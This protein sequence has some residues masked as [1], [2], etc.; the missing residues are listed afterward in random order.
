M[1]TSSSYG[2]PKDTNQLIPPW[3]RPEIDPQSP[4]EPEK[5]S[6]PPQET[7]KQNDKTK[8]W[9]K[10]KNTMSR[11]ASNGGGV[12]RLRKAGSAYTAAKGGA[13]KAAALAASGKK[14][15]KRIALF[16]ATTASSGISEG[17]RS[18]GLSEL[19]GKDIDTV[20]N[21]IFEALT[22]KGNDFDSAIA[23]QAMEDALIEQYSQCSKNNNF[24]SMEHLDSTQ[25]KESIESYVGSYVY[26]KWLQELGNCIERKSVSAKEAVKLEKEVKVFV[27]D[28][29][30]LELGS[31]DILTIDWS[32]DEGESV[33]SSIFEDVYSLLGDNE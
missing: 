10:A 8:K 24:D 27:N 25:I 31:R 3:A 5:D 28:L 17:L 18:I 26:K 13:K 32:S 16:L 33:I 19:V 2:G 30:S 7:P 23:R 14:S 22:D 4:T 1:G 20:F 9:Q 11:Y 12:D 29:V 6:N 21:G 15:A